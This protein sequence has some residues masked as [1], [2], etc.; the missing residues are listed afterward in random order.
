MQ[1]SEKTIE[2]VKATAPLV[3]ENAVKITSTFYPILFKD[4][5]ETKIMFNQSHQRDGGQPKALAAAVVA[6]ALNIDNLGVLGG[7]VEEM[8]ER[9]ASLNIR[10]EH[11]PMVGA[12]LIKAIG[13]VLGD[14]VT[15]DI[16]EAWTEAYGFLANILITTERGKYD[17]TLAKPGGWEGY[18]DFTVAEKK[19]ES[20]S[21]TSFYLKPADGSAIVPYEAG[22]YISIKIEMPGEPVT[23]R[24][25]SLSD[26]DTD[27]LRISVKK[28]GLVSKYLHDAV[29]QGDAISINPP[30]GV[31]KLNDS[32]K[33]AVL[34]SGGVGITPML[35]MLKQLSKTGSA[36][37]V[38][39]LHGSQNPESHAFKNEVKEICEANHYLYEYYYSDSSQYIGIKDLQRTCE[40]N[41]D[42]EFY[43]CGP[44]PMMK[45]IY[46]ALSDWGV[47]S[48]NIFY[49]YFGPKGEINA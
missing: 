13:E 2:I 3:G 43:I 19:V 41:P 8:A 6:Y 22:Q 49:E 21:I 36:R 37:K 45:T 18:K 32:E 9:H 26:W 29:Q 42:S 23:V 27:Y 47:P 24:N 12:S 20:D 38:S 15:P 16:A 39:F 7:A 31:L 46:A 28:D 48:T 10:P 40:N 34:I 11:Y 44:G 14:A 17:A 33:P 5:P 4:F 25:Y 30:Y 35:S 1:L